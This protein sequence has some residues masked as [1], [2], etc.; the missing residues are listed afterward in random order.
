MWWYSHGRK[1]G[2]KREKRWGAILIGILLLASL[3]HVQSTAKADWIGWSI[4]I[5][6]ILGGVWLIAFGAKGSLVN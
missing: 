3:G 5:L 4:N 2:E 1:P 6:R